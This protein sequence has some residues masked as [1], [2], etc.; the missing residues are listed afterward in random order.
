MTTS[1]QPK[2]SPLTALPMQFSLPTRGAAEYRI[3]YTLRLCLRVAAVALMLFSAVI[4][5][6][7]AATSQTLYKWSD[8]GKIH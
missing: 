7:F 2:L 5:M 8:D 1:L 6:V 4:A 3:K